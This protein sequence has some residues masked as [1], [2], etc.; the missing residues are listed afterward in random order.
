MCNDLNTNLSV[1]G[2]L[3][4]ITIGDMVESTLPYPGVVLVVAGLAHPAFIIGGDGGETVAPVVGIGVGG[5]PE[6]F[7]GGVAIDIAFFSGAVST[8]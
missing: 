7:R 4:N 2:V 8:R 3:G 1:V 6:F 5:G